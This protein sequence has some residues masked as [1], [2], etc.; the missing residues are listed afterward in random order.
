MSLIN[1]NVHIS[2]KTVIRMDFF[3]TETWRPCPNKFKVT[4]NIHLHWGQLWTY[5]CVLHVVYPWQCLSRRT[6]EPCG[7][8]SLRSLKSPLAHIRGQFGHIEHTLCSSQFSQWTTLRLQESCGPPCAKDS[9]LEQDTDSSYLWGCPWPLTFLQA[10]NHLNVCTSSSGNSGNTVVICGVQHAA[11]AVDRQWEVI[12][13][14]NPA[15]DTNQDLPVLLPQQTVD[16]WVGGGLDIGQTL[17]GDAPVPWDV[18]RG[19]QLHQPA[20]GIRA[21]EVNSVGPDTRNIDA[22]FCPA[23]INKQTIL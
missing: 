21:E 8:S 2:L 9:I 19:Q 7:N 10:L 18:H 16:E 23:Q 17:G 22:H 5:C 13:S 11:R 14:Q 1:T 12:L 6:D 4:S 3:F 15:D 20:G